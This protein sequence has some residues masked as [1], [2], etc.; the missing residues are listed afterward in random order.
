MRLFGQRE[1]K[2]AAVKAACERICAMVLVLE[3][4]LELCGT[5]PAFLFSR[6]IT[7]ARAENEFAYRQSLTH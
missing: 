7:Q 4:L 5:G 2:K 3:L 6:L 1:T